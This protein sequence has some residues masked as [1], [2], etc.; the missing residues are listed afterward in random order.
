MPTSIIT[1]QT[2]RQIFVAS[3]FL[4][5]WVS[6]CGAGKSLSSS[7]LNYAYFKPE[8]SYSGPL[9]RLE[10]LRQG[11]AVDFDKVR[12]CVEVG[13]STIGDDQLLLETKLAYGAWLDAAGGYTEDDWRKFDFIKEAKCHSNDPSFA[14]F[15]VLVDQAKADPGEDL[16]SDFQPEHISCTTGGGFKR[17]TGSGVTLGW[18]GPGQMEYWYQGNQEKWVKLSSYRPSSTRLSPFVRWLPLGE[19][20][21][22]N[23]VAGL[24]DAHKQKLIAN[25]QAMVP[26]GDVALADLSAMVKDLAAAQLAT[27]DDPVFGQSMQ[28][29]YDGDDT[30]IDKDYQ[31][32]RGTFS[33]ILHEVGHQYGMDHAHHPGQDSLTGQSAT[34]KQNAG[35]QWVTDI[36]A[37]AYGVPYLYLTADD[38]AGVQADKAAILAFLATKK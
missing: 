35:G 8:T 24:D 36:S 37:M 9:G 25:Y 16:A 10:L 38:I 13:K 32:E 15:V 29:F 23:T 12:I 1:P 27:A 20:I 14:G 21:Q 7:G 33:T 26:S 19:D 3:L 18:G 6:G 17:C 4:G 22:R 5:M 34:T 2:S 11:F 30:Q 31:G 28:S